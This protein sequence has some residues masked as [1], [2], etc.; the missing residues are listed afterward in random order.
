MSTTQKWSAVLA[1]ASVAVAYLL[2]RGI[3]AG[4]D[5][6]Q[7]MCAV[8]LAGGIGGLLNGFMPNQGFALPQRIKRQAKIE[9]E[10]KPILVNILDPGFVGTVLVGIAAAAV[11]FALYGPLKDLVV[12]GPD[13]VE[14]PG[15]KLSELFVSVIVGMGGGRLLTKEVDE[16]ITKTT[17]AIN[18]A[19]PANSKVAAAMGIL[20]SKDVLLAVTEPA[21]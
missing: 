11:L 16:K 12:F 4:S 17:A 7:V 6:V 13:K 8:G 19:K 10:D 14:M 9:G 2:Y 21:D 18:A 5:I 3:T 20:P 15:V 1:V